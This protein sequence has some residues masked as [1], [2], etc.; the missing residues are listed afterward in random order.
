MELLQVFDASAPGLR[1]SRYGRWDFR[2]YESVNV[3]F[4]LNDFIQI[5]EKHLHHMG[6]EMYATIFP[7]VRDRL[8]V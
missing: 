2:H 3:P 6:I 8:L 4:I 1:L 7:D 5:F